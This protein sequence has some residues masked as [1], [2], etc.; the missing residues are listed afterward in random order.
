MKPPKVLWVFVTCDGDRVVEKIFSGPRKFCG[1]LM[2]FVGPGG[3]EHV[4]GTGRRKKKI[5][6]PGSFVGFCG[7][8]GS[9]PNQNNYKA[10]LGRRVPDMPHTLCGECLMLMCGC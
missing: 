1:C 2:V 9:H 7:G 4:T 3:L 5:Q 6:A 10:S 8:R